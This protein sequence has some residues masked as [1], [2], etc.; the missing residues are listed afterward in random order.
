[1]ANE[2][3]RHNLVSNLPLLFAGGYPTS[4][5]KMTESQLERFIPFMV[6][7]SLGN[8]QIVNAEYSEPE[9]WPDTVPFSIPLRTSTYGPEWLDR[10]KSIVKICY[11]FHNNTFLLRFC[12]QLAAYQPE[13]LRFIGNYNDTTSLFERSSNKLLATFRNEN[14]LYDQGSVNKM[15]KITLLSSRKNNSQSQ[16]IEETVD[17]VETVFEIYLCDNCEAEL[18]TKEAYEEH[19]KTCHEDDDVIF[20]GEE[21]LTNPLDEPHEQLKEQAIFLQNFSLGNPNLPLPTP[22]KTPIKKYMEESS[23]GVKRRMP[24]CS[25]IILSSNVP[26]SSPAG[27]QLLKLSKTHLAHGY[28]AEK[29]ERTER[30][31]CAP[32]LTIGESISTRIKPYKYNR[33]PVTYRRPQDQTYRWYNFHRRQYFQRGYRQAFLNLNCEELKICKPVTIDLPKVSIQDIE[34]FN[35]Q[36]RCE[37]SMNTDDMPDTALFDQSTTVDVIDLCSDD[38]SDNE[39]SYTHGHYD[40]SNVSQTAITPASTISPSSFIDPLQMPFEMYTKASAQS[41]ASVFNSDTSYQYQ[42]HETHQSFLNGAQGSIVTQIDTLTE[43]MDISIK[44]AEAEEA[45][46]SIDLTL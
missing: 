44:A 31:C 37:E 4:L 29:L 1:M 42:H 27:Q 39:L 2:T 36:N 3:T 16:M 20:C 25:Q 9:W 23:S 21:F 19:E 41:T 5:E 10:L 45:H 35:S 46:I 33:I 7:C 6:Q 43:F 22:P 34:A 28:V 38:D 24:R 8:V 13:S 14:M 11:R 40:N 15:S 12:H 17:A 30:H 32:P 26:F 18:Y